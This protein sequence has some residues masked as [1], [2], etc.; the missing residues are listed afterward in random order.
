MEHVNGAQVP[1][2]AFFSSGMVGPKKASEGC[3]SSISFSGCPPNSA[4]R[5][6]Q[7]SPK[8]IIG[9]NGIQTEFQYRVRQIQGNTRQIILQ[10]KQ[11][12]RCVPGLARK[13]RVRG[14]VGPVHIA[15]CEVFQI[16]R[17]FLQSSAESGE[18]TMGSSKPGFHICF[19]R[20]R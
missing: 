5:S 18:E 3:Q 1:G 19:L 6:V 16:T 20:V 2:I 9:P 11:H 8:S 14:L 13:H 10:P 15:F 17:G 12:Q 4:F 7:K